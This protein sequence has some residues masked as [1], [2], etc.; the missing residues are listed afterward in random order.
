MSLWDAR[1][2]R[3]LCTGPSGCSASI[4][5]DDEARTWWMNDRD[6]R[7]AHERL[8]RHQGAVHVTNAYEVLDVSFLE[9]LAREAHWL[10]IEGLGGARN[11][12]REAARPVAPP[13]NWCADKVGIAIRF[14]REFDPAAH[15]DAERKA[16]LTGDEHEPCGTCVRGIGDGCRKRGCLR[17]QYYAFAVAGLPGFDW[18]ADA[19]ADVVDSEDRIAI[20]YVREWDI[21]P[22][23][24]PTRYPPLEGRPATDEEFEASAARMLEKHRRSLAKLAG[25]PVVD[26]HELSR[27]ADDGGPADEDEL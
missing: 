25:A 10:K 3:R 21:T 16:R 26:N 11:D 15:E 20:R 7:V 27:M 6:P 12:D 24:H 17:Q 9:K 1:D 5:Y 2:L 8:V 22:D 13:A 19:S 18:H 4:W 23:P 14:I